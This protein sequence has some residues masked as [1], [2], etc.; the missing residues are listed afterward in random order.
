MNSNPNLTKEI[1]RLVKDSG[2]TITGRDAYWGNL[3]STIACS[4]QKID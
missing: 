4:T 1:D 2:C 3:I